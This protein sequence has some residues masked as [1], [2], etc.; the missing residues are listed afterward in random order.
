[1]AL[2]FPIVSTISITMALKVLLPLGQSLLP[3][4]G[5]RVLKNHSPGS[6]LSAPLSPEMAPRNP[7]TPC[8]L[9]WGTIRSS[10]SAQHPQSSALLSAVPCCQPLLSTSVVLLQTTARWSSHKLDAALMMTLKAEVMPLSSFLGTTM[11]P[12][13][14]K[15]RGQIFPWHLLL[16][17]VPSCCPRALQCTAVSYS[18]RVLLAKSDRLNEKKQCLSFLKR[19]ETIKGNVIFLPPP[20]LLVLSR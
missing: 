17:P 8:A 9:P 10:A 19:L 3:R 12:P 5:T 13:S 14:E 7:F 20:R 1:M 2:T 4:R 6:R 18:L 16:P 15:E 11:S